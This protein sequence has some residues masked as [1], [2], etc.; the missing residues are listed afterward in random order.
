MLQGLLLLFFVIVMGLEWHVGRTRGR[1]VFRVSDATSNLLLGMVQLAPA[2]LLFGFLQVSYEFIYQRS[3]AFEIKANSPIGWIG[4]LIG[5]DFCYYWFHRFSHRVH[6]AWTSHALHHQGEDYN[7]TLGIRQH[8]AQGFFERAFYLPLAFIGFPPRMAAIAVTI[9]AAYQLFLHTELVGKLGSLEC[10]LNT[11]SHHR[12]HHGI[13]TRYLD[14]NFGGML[15]IWDRMF[16]TFAEEHEQPVYGT[17]EPIASFDPVHCM[18]TP[19]DDAIERA[20]RTPDSLHELGVWIMP[21]D[22]RP[23]SM[24]K[25]DTQV[26]L[27]RPKYDVKLSRG[28]TLYLMAMTG[29]TIAMMIYFLINNDLDPRPRTMQLAFIAWTAVTLVGL[30]GLIEGRPW[31]KPVEALRLV[32][33]PFVVMTLV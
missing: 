30:G 5:V 28:T 16:G 22:W 29:L 6:V 33:T 11:P 2:V 13:N 31:A 15:I 27:D 9:N 12:V 32:A 24:A 4:L 25:A 8:P 1:Q 3:A 23:K 19:L 7:L 20:S 21:P 10:V 26:R 14:K 17:V 18:W